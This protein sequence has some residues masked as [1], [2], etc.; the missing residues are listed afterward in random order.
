MYPIIPYFK[1][2]REWIMRHNCLGYNVLW[3]WHKF[4][5]KCTIVLKEDFWGKLTN[6]NFVNLL[7]PI[8]QKYFKTKL[9]GI[10]WD[11]RSNNFGANWVQIVILLEKGIFWENWQMLLLFTDYAP[12]CYKV[13]KMSLAYG[14]SWGTRCYSFGP[15]WTQITDLHL[16]R[17]FFFE[18]YTNA[19][20]DYFMYLI[21]ILQSSEKTH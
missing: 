4:C 7:Y 12:V 19:N 14:R 2:F 8:M 16:K 5:P 15:N 10:S 13:S 11:I 1:I 17:G 6:A 21:K 9:C 3:F 18:K 20:F